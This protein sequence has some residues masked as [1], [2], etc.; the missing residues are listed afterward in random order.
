MR[1]RAAR[2]AV[3]ALLLL[4]AAGA[5]PPSASHAPG[6][7][8]AASTTPDG[9]AVMA[10]MDEALHYAGRDMKAKVRMEL[11]STGQ[12]TRYRVMTMLRSSE[13]PGGD[14]RYLLYFHE[15][16]DARRMACLVYKHANAPDERWMYVPVTGRIQRVQSPDR[17]S[18]LGSDFVREEFSGRDV[19]S[20]T[21]RVIGRERMMERDC[22]VVESVPRRPE[23]FARSVTWVDAERWLPVRQEFWSHRGV[24]ARLLTFEQ[25]ESF[26]SRADAR[27]THPYPRLWTARN[28]LANHWTTI[29]LD[30]IVY[31]IGLKPTDFVEARLLEQP[32]D[33]LP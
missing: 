25:V 6:D 15:P 21:H 33:W 27:V 10:R 20:D 23:E 2:L 31:D 4:A 1:T 14:E 32:G 18:F 9:R 24:L 3:S 12:P 19:N 28:L 13:T 16:G 5:A 26:P 30:S 22:Y 8:Q 17:S 7:G 29:Q 11:G